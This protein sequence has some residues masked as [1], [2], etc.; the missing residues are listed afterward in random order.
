M[1]DGVWAST[2][3]V[4]Y[5]LT[6]KHLLLFVIILSRLA[7]FI[8]D[9]VLIPQR[10]RQWF[11]SVRLVSR[12][13]FP[14]PNSGLRVFRRVFSNLWP[15]LTAVVQHAFELCGLTLVVAHARTQ[16]WL[17][18]WCLNSN[19]HH[20]LSERFGWLFIDRRAELLEGLLKQMMFSLLIFSEI[21]Q[22]IV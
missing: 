4:D 2:A 3:Q 14:F 21:I 18:R 13:I 9:Y 15:T 1:F 7:V 11:S 12:K 10:Q 5:F 16:M 6:R 17:I 19:I 22:L 20:S 8:S